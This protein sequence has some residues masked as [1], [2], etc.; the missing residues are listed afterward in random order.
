MQL[1]SLAAKLK[2]QR[3]MGVDQTNILKGKN[4]ALIFTKPSMRTRGDRHRH[5]RIG[6]RRGACA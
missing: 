3:K 2:L 6:L 1:L 4:I 5:A